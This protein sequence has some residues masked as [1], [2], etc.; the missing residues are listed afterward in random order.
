MKN[1]F[2]TALLE[3]VYEIFITQLNYSYNAS[4][5]EKYNYIVFECNCFPI[6]FI[7][8]SKKGN[9]QRSIINIRFLF[10]Q[11]NDLRVQIEDDIIISSME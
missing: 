4:L 8:I 9:N 1:V 7:P 11:R 2:I 10:V 5:T 6:L 3:N